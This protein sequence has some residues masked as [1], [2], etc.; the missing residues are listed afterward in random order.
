MTAI[1]KHSFSYL[2][3]NYNTVMVGFSKGKTISYLVH[4]ISSMMIDSDKLVS[5]NY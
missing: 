2:V 3:N 5:Y 1:Q 4:I